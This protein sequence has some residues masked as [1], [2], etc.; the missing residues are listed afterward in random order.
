MLNEIEK[1][2]FEKE[3]P[4]RSCLFALR[5]FILKYDKN[6]TEEWKYGIPIFCYGGK[7]FCYLWV[8]KKTKQP[9]LSIVE[10]KR[11]MHPK[12]ISG[13]RSRMKIMY[14]NPEKDLPVKTIKAIFKMALK[15]YRIPE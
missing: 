15:F 6:M 7:M 8:A 5:H 2:Y 3:E 12:L 9:Y 13:N 11:I 14:L 1:F 4:T 10:G